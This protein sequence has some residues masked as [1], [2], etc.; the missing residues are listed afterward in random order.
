[1]KWSQIRGCLESGGFKPRDNTLGYETLQRAAYV[2]SWCSC[3][4]HWRSHHDQRH[5]RGMRSKLK[6]CPP[7]WIAWSWRNLAAGA[8][9]SRVGQCLCHVGRCGTRHSGDTW[10]RSSMS[11]Q[12]ICS[13]LQTILAH[14]SWELQVR[15]LAKPT[16]FQPIRQTN[17]GWSRSCWYHRGTQCQRWRRDLKQ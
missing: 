11:K 4:I 7:H 17:G 8:R 9:S 2:E 16:L 5:V 1:M 12:R 15:L 3:E 6:V 13:H 14:W 10:T